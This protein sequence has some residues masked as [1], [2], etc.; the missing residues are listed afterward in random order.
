VFAYVGD[1]AAR[2]MGVGQWTL[3]RCED[4]AVRRGMPRLWAT[5]ARY[6]TVSIN[7]LRQEGF[8]CLGE[9]EDWGVFAEKLVRGRELGPL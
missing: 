2:G 6:N 4:E 5:A 8:V 1:A 7:T 3:R 9:H